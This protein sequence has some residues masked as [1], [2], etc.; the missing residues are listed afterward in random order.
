[1]NLKLRIMKKA[2]I[3]TTLTIIFIIALSCNSG[4]PKA[5]NKDLKQKE[6]TEVYYTCPMH[7]EIHSDKPGTC[8]KCGMA[9]VEAK[10]PDAGTVKKNNPDSLN[11]N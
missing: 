3:S 5:V 9:L 2:I 6:M 8:P 10:T 1:M 7:P 4:S 11:R